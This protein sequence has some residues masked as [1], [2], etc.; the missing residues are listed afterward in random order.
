MGDRAN[1][2]VVEAGSIVFLY[3]HNRG[4]ELPVIWR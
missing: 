4:T 3:T 1:V 2:K